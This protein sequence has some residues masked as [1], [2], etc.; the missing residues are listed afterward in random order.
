M[1]EIEESANLCDSDEMIADS[2]GSSIDSSDSADNS[3]VNTN[4]NNL[5]LDIPQLSEG[6]M[7][8]TLYLIYH[9]YLIQ[10]RAN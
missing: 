7:I 3:S 2:G 10:I 6:L 5:L 8:S 1:N 9:S 4:N